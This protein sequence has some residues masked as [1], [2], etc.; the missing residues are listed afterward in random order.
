MWQGFPTQRRDAHFAISGANAN[1][2]VLRLSVH[3]LTT[4][5]YEYNQGR[6]EVS[7]DLKRYKYQGV[8]GVG[9]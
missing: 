8:F 9:A 5:I 4:V 2:H 3:D 6:I 7:L 1:V